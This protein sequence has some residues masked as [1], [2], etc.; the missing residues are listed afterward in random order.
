MHIK[1]IRILPLLIPTVSGIESSAGPETVG[2]VV[3]AM[4]VSDCTKGG[5]VRS[6]LERSRDRPPGAMSQ[7]PTKYKSN[8]YKH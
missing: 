1:N 3:W 6:T 8:T 7:S 4:V 2:D 5:G